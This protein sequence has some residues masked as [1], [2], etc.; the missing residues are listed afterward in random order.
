MLC[1]VI[2]SWF[3]LLSF[4]N[5]C[6]C[7]S[8]VT[9]EVPFGPIRLKGRHTPPQLTATTLNKLVQ[10]VQLIFVVF[11][12][13]A[14]QLRWCACVCVIVPCLMNY[15]GTLL[16]SPSPH[17]FAPSQDE[18]TAKTSVMKFKFSPKVEVEMGRPLR[19]AAGGSLRLIHPPTKGSVR[20]L[21]RGGGTS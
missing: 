3:L 7:L 13:M 6:F 21:W 17:P 16:S 12:F 20:R 18:V 15:G 1:W 14:N 10:K 11:V 19:S 5:V 2:G 4:L 8:E 9:S